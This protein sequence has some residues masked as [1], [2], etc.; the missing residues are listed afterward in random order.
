[1]ESLLNKLN[2]SFELTNYMTYKK[3]KAVANKAESQD[4]AKC[5]NFS[6][7]ACRS[8]IPNVTILRGKSQPKVSYREKF[9]L[10]FLTLTLKP[11]ERREFRSRRALKCGEPVFT[12][13]GRQIVGRASYLPQCSAEYSSDEQAWKTGQM[14]CGVHHEV[15][16]DLVTPVDG[17]EHDRGNH[18]EIFPTLEGIEVRMGDRGLKNGMDSRGNPASKVKKRRRDTGD[19]N[20]YAWRLIAPT[21]RRA[22]FA[23]V[24]GGSGVELRVQGQGAIRATLTRTPSTSSLLRAKSS[25]AMEGWMEQ[26]WTAKMGNAITSRKPSG[27]RQRPPRFLY[28][29]IGAQTANLQGLLLLDSLDSIPARPHSAYPNIQSEK[30]GGEFAIVRCVYSEFSG[31][32]LQ[33]PSVAISP[34]GVIHGQPSCKRGGR[35]FSGISRFPRPF[36]P[37]PLRPLIFHPPPPSSALKTSTFTVP[38]NF[39]EALLNVYVQDSPI[40]PPHAKEALKKFTLGSTHRALG[41]IFTSII[42]NCSPDLADKSRPNLFTHSLHARLTHT[43]STLLASHQGEPVST[44]GRVAPGFSQVGTVP[45]VAAG[46]WVFSGISRFPHPPSSPV[47]RHSHLISPS[48]ALNTWLLRASQRTHLESRCELQR[49]EDWQVDV[50]DNEGHEDR[51]DERSGVLGAVHVDLRRHAHQRYARQVAAT[52]K[53]PKSISGNH[54]FK[55]HPSI[56][57][58]SRLGSSEVSVEQRRNAGEGESGDPSENPPTSGIVRTIPTCENPGATLSRIEL[59]SPK[60]G[61]REVRELHYYRT[62]APPTGIISCVADW[63]AKMQSDK[64]SRNFK[65]GI[66][67]LEDSAVFANNVKTPRMDYSCNWD[68]RRLFRG[69]VSSV[70]RTE[71]SIRYRRSNVVGSEFAITDRRPDETP[72]L[73]PYSLP[74]WWSRNYVFACEKR[75]G[76]SPLVGGFS[77]GIPT[78]PAIAFNRCSISSLRCLNWPRRPHLNTS[79]PTAPLAH[80]TNP[81]Q[82]PNPTSDIHPHPPNYKNS[83][84][85]THTHS[86]NPFQCADIYIRRSHRLRTGA[87]LAVAAVSCETGEFLATVAYADWKTSLLARFTTGDDFFLTTL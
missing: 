49:E 78:Y 39:S 72:K 5:W 26:R 4:K 7:Q 28:A 38:F 83:Q 48:S 9:C 87:L 36:V 10:E 50:V 25:P 75:D 2:Y 15:R 56:K 61:R 8:L 13:S 12:P 44:P 68:E 82:H 40:P 16:Q 57:L 59:G 1:M 30:P 47:L 3:I 66:L 42:V 69:P 73:V 31:F 84:R 71:R 45:D 62:A 76:L 32:I 54:R 41:S 65:S 35:V 80:L 43:R 55:G 14:V 11:D 6:K 74:T 63:D 23:S 53:Q 24:S 79:Y 37:A 60:R 27:E 33:M 17:L 22:V 20:T 51:R 70:P 34:C 85:T 58:V 77:R 81:N 18:I 86:L 52:H 19:T 29:K 64:N 67:C 46:P 21:C